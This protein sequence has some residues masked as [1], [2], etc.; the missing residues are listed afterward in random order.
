MVNYD[1]MII[2]QLIPLLN[3]WDLKQ[4]AAAITNNQASLYQVFIWPVMSGVSRPVNPSPFSAKQLVQFG[5]PNTP[6][7]TDAVNELFVGQVAVTTGVSNPVAPDVEAT[8]S[9]ALSELPGPTKNGESLKILIPGQAV[10]AWATGYEYPVVFSSYRC[11][12]TQASNSLTLNLQGALI[13][14]RPKP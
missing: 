6:F 12:G 4:L 14:W 7:I 10:G 11:N 2:E 13:Q 5:D 3:Q 9:I 8:F 1:N